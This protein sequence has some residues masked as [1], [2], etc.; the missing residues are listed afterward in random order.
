VG[1]ILPVLIV[2]WV[3]CGFIGYAIGSNKNAGGFGFVLGFLLGPIGVVAAALADMRAA[4]PHCGTKL[5]GQPANCPA[6]KT[7]FYWC[8]NECIY[9]PPD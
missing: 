5:N 9:F 3:I 6:C 4:C 7:K 2:I 1:D 8:G